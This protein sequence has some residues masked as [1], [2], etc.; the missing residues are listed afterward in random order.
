MHLGR[1]RKPTMQVHE[2][3]SRAPITISADVDVHM[4]L[5][6]LQEGAVRRLPV[7]DAGGR[8]LGIVTERDLLLA[9][10]HYLNI[11][12]EVET[13]MTRPV[14]ATTPD[15]PLAEAA[16]LM[17]NHKIGGMPVVGTDQQLVGII[18]ESDIFRAF[19]SLLGAGSALQ[20]SSAGA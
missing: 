19:V 16:M 6:L 11:P 15:A 18:T 2:H 5:R 9:V 7:T 12:I 8:V 14:V 20:T 10:S 17:V 1:E 4:A 3:M 13:I